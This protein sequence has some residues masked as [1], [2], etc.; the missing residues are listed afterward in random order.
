VAGV[1]TLASTKKER[2]RSGKD[3]RSLAGIMTPIQRRFLLSLVNNPLAPPDQKKEAQRILG[4]QKQRSLTKVSLERILV[5]TQEEAQWIAR[6]RHADL[7]RRLVIA[8]N[9]IRE[10]KLD[11]IARREW[12]QA[13]RL[14]RNIVIVDPQ[15]EK[16]IRN[17]FQFSVHGLDVNHVEMHHILVRYG[18]PLPEATRSVRWGARVLGIQRIT[19][20]T[21]RKIHS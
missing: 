13:L 17:G 8:Q 15:E 16:K 18:M 1:L 11:P 3:T 5:M 4:I 20:F 7:A 21:Y 2:E 19:R 10:N 12:N 14:F 6:N 9:K